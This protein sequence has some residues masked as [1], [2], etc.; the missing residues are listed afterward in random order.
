VLFACLGRREQRRHLPLSIAVLTSVRAAMLGGACR[1]GHACCRRSVFAPCE[2]TGSPR[3][4]SQP[5]PPG[6]GREGRQ[7]C[8]N[9]LV[10]LRKAAG[11]RPRR[12]KGPT[13]STSSAGCAGHSHTSVCRCPVLVDAAATR[14][15]ARRARE[16]ATGSSACVVTERAA[17]LLAELSGSRQRR[18]AFA[19]GHVEMARNNRKATAAVMRCGC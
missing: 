4:W 11:V 6:R 1:E 5:I 7:R 13:L 10:P 9:P 17:G 16:V 14:S 15:A 12:R 18:F 2:S 3:T 19:V 8:S